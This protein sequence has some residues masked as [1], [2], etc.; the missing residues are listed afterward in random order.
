MTFHNEIKTALYS[1]LTGSSTW[2]TNIGGRVYYLTAPQNPTYP[3]CVFSIFADSNTFDSASEWEETFWQF[4]IF[5]KDS[6]SGDIGTLESNLIDLLYGFEL[7]P[8][9]YTQIQFRREANRY[10]PDPLEGVYHTILEYRTE[11]Q[12]D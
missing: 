9:N 7:E 1:K 10:I 8:T 2:N 3:Y 12:H 4:S 6:S 11:F 5:D